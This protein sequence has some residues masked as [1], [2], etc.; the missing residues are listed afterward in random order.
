MH[1]E[2]T[3]FGLHARRGEPGL[4][5]ML[6]EKNQVCVA[7]SE[8]RTSP[9][10]R[11]LRRRVPSP[12]PLHFVPLGGPTSVV[13]TPERIAQSLPYRRSLRSVGAPTSVVATPARAGVLS[14][15]PGP[16][17]PFG[18]KVPATEAK[19][20]SEVRGPAKRHR[21]HVRGIVEKGAYCRVHREEDR[22]RWVGGR[23]CD[24]DSTFGQQVCTMAVCF[25][26]MGT[27]QTGRRT[28]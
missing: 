5:C 25:P 17:V 26:P 19:R 8:R 21:Q 23:V 6:G 7:C 20:R 11:R 3:R 9:P 14:V 22:R 12:R 10:S 16:K 2:G 27:H 28:P 1:R 4:R 18:G 24:T 13:A 15:P